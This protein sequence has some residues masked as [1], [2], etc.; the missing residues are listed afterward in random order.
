[1]KRSYALLLS[2]LLASHALAE[3][4]YELEEETTII[5]G[6]QEMLQWTPHAVTVIKDEEIDVTYRHDLE[7]LQGFAPGLIVVSLSGTPQGAAISIRGVDTS[8][9]KNGIFELGVAVKVDGVYVGTHASQM[10]VLFDFEQVEVARGPQGTL[11][12]APNMGGTI[13]LKR[14][15]PT[16]SFD[17]D[18]RTS[19]G[20]NNSKKVDV[21][22]NFPITKSIAG[23][24]TH[25]AKR[26]GGD[27]I[28]ANYHNFLVDNLNIPEEPFDL[29][30]LDPTGHRER[31][32]I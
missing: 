12:G 16:G 15:K 14:R 13:H 25:S 1:M 24:V 5:R 9:V 2:I 31:V 3:K 6:E 23:K 17:V 10:Q 11:E 4:Q 18:L 7:D 19:F 28:N 27:Y 29:R 22:I 21:A 20:E 26:N 32:H 30:G 8:D